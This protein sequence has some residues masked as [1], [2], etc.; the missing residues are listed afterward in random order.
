MTGTIIMLVAALLCIAVAGSAKSAVDILTHQPDNNIFS[1]KGP[2][3]DA[4]TSWK[5]KYK[6]YDAGDLTP[7]FW[8]STKWLV[9]LTDFWH[10]A[11]SVYLQLYALGFYL[12]GLVACRL[13][14]EHAALIALLIHTGLFSGSRLT[15]GVVFEYLYQKVFRVRPTA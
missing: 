1:A 4:R 15:F 2:W 3:Y 14:A 5:L 13:T 7:R 10:A 6:D 8:G 9:M 11:D 12:L